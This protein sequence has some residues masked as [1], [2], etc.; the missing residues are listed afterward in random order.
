MNTENRKIFHVFLGRMK[1]AFH[2]VLT[3]HFHVCSYVCYGQILRFL[4]L[5]QSLE[6]DKKEVKC[7]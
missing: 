7:N 1:P 4:L 2:I 5:L 6:A 3:Y